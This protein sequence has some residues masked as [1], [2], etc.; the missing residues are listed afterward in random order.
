MLVTAMLLYTVYSRKRVQGVSS[1]IG[2]LALFGGQKDV[3]WKLG[4]GYYV[5]WAT[6]V[7]SL[8]AFVFP[9][10]IFVHKMPKNIKITFRRSY[11]QSSSKTMST[12]S[13]AFDGY[14]LSGHFQQRSISRQESVMKSSKD[15]RDANDNKQ[16][17]EHADNSPSK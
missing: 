13:T 1:H 4:Y 8:V 3:K 6:F 2:L 9:A 11:S 5:G 17:T 7:I 14:E 10:Y 15:E 12:C 16:Q